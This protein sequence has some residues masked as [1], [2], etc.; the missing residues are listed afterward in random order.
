MEE[1][2]IV[3]VSCTPLPDGWWH[4]DARSRYLRATGERPSQAAAV[5]AAV[6]EARC[7]LRN[8]TC[9][10]SQRNATRKIR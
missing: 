8:F 5:D 6:E 2:V 7:Q 10:K 3:S 9:D 4:Y 1:S